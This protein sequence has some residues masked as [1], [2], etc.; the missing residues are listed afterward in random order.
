[1]D[2]IQCT[3]GDERKK[4]SRS[5]SRWEPEAKSVGRGTFFKKKKRLTQEEAA[6]QSPEEE[7][8]SQGGTQEA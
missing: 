7:T 6:P 2:N 3:L 4:H 5:L 1:M 8:A